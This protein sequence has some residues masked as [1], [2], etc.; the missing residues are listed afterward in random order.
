MVRLRVKELAQERGISMSKLSRIADVSY[1]TIQQM[2]R[3]PDHGFNSKTLERVAK[4]LQVEMG[5]LFE[6][7]PDK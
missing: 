2:Y 7:V 4:A 1:K 5:D 6:N 3:Y